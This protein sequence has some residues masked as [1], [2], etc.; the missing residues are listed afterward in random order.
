ME[1]KRK[2]ADLQKKRLEREM[3]TKRKIDALTQKNGDSAA[4]GQLTAKE[5]DE[6]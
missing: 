6:L 2:L 3:E 4:G 5:F 1:V